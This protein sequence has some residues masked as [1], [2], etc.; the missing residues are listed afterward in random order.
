MSALSVTNAETVEKRSNGSAK[1][2]LPSIRLIQRRHSRAA[3]FNSG[4]PAE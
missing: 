2:L 4:F 1:P 3:E